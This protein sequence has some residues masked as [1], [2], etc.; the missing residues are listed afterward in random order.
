MLRV[1]QLKAILITKVMKN[2][3]REFRS[4][5]D[6]WLVNR[7]FHVHLRSL[8]PSCDFLNFYLAWV[9]TSLAVSVFAW[10][11]SENFVV[12]C[13]TKWND[14]SSAM[15]TEMTNTYYSLCH[16]SDCTFTRQTTHPVWTFW[17]TYSDYPNQAFLDDKEGNKIKK[18]NVKSQV[19]IVT[20][21]KPKN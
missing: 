13:S 5:T 9:Q 11:V 2:L 6:S 4:C 3:G 8:I 10:L 12:L 16:I 1:M 14:K 7:I 17:L 21:T 19:P 20:D 15:K 18:G